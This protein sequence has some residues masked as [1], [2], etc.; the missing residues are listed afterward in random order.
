MLHNVRGLC[1]N[2]RFVHMRHVIFNCELSVLD[3]HI[4]LASPEMGHADQNWGHNGIQR[5]THQSNIS[6]SMLKM[7]SNFGIFPRVEFIEEYHNSQK[8]IAEGLKI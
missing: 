1:K 6:K 2:R 5:A 4:A 3:C 7:R 8:L